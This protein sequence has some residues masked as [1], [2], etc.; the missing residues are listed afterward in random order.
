MGLKVRTVLA[1]LFFWVALFGQAPDTLWTRTYGVDYFDEGYSVQQTSDGG[2]IVTGRTGGGPNLYHLWLIKTDSLGDSLW[3]KKFGA[4]S[5]GY[6]VQQTMDGG[7]IIT[8]IKALSNNSDPDVWLIKTDSNGDTLWTRTFG[9]SGFDWGNFVQQTSDSGFIITGYTYSFSVGS[10]DAWLIK[11]D[12]SGDTLWTRTFGGSDWDNGRFVQQTLDGGYI[13]ATETYSFGAGSN[14]AWLI[15]TDA[16]GDSIWTRTIG[17]GGSDAAY[18]VR[19]NINGG[20]YVLAGYTQSFGDINGDVLLAKVDENGNTLWIK[21]IGGDKGDGALSVQQTSDRGFFITGYTH[22]FGAG[23]GDVYLIKTDASGDTVWTKSIG[24]VDWDEGWSGRYTSDGGYVVTGFTESFGVFYRD[25]WLIKIAPGVAAV[26]EPPHA[27]VNV[28]FLKQNYPNPFNPKTT[29]E[30]AI[31][32]RQF[33]SLKVYDLLGGE[34][35]VLVNEEK[36]AGEHIVEL[37]ASQLSSGIYFY[38]LRAGSYVKTKKM[39]VMK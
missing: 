6:A 13:I 19:Q 17:G 34:I 36:P 3:T 14:D 18:S 38:R 7:F 21:T 26:K 12:A 15:K 2:Y 5:M 27:I 23:S 11:T 20:W 31:A 1:N 25:L 28:Y 39:I 9:G 29:L 32:S 4:V 37:D 35:A 22:S 8:G 16:N 33:V 10:A 24:G 30:Y